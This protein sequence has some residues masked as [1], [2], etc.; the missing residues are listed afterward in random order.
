MA[1]QSSYGLKLLK[2]FGF[3]TERLETIILKDK[4]GLRA[5]DVVVMSM[6]P[7]M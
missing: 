7:S 2:K 4:N 6:L 1:F 3:P 5:N